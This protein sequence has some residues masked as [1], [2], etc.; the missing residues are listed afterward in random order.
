MSLQRA[1]PVPSIQSVALE[2]FKQLS[3]QGA[4]ALRTHE[5][6]VEAV[7]RTSY[8]LIC[9]RFLD[10]TVLKV[11]EVVVKFLAGMDAPVALK[12][13]RTLSEP[14]LTHLASVSTQSRMGTPEIVGILAQVAQVRRNRAA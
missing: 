12:H 7:V 4:D 9:S 5:Q 8:E 11:V 1:L 2:G 14:A 6:F 13:V 3:M 10:P